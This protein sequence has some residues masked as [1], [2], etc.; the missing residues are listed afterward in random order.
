MAPLSHGKVMAAFSADGRDCT[1][2]VGSHNFTRK[3]WGKPGSMRAVAGAWSD[4]WPGNIELGVV[5]TAATRQRS[6]ELFDRFPVT[7]PS[8]ADL[9]PR[10][11]GGLGSCLERGY[12]PARVPSGGGPGDLQSWRSNPG[13]N[14]IEPRALA[15]F[16][17]ALWKGWWPEDHARGRPFPFELPI[18]WPDEDRYRRQARKHAAARQRARAPGHAA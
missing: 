10:S 18:W 17:I 14:T 5:L 11:A 9:G 2:Y 13:C 6:R 16:A 12:D 8:I 3:A 1:L 7:L 4:P 15:D